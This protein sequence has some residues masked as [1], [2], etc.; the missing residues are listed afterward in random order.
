MRQGTKGPDSGLENGLAGLKMCRGLRRLA[1]NLIGAVACAAALLASPVAWAQD[2]LKIAA[3]VNDDVITQLDVYM[4]LRLAMLSAHL[5]DTPDTRQRLLPQVMRTLIDDHLKLQEAKS[6]GVTVG[7]GDVNNRIDNLA[8]RNGLSRADFESM[9]AS[10]GV[11]VTALADQMRADVSWNRLVQRK[12]R[13]TIRITDE[14][15]NEAEARDKA[16]LG[17]L[18]YHLSQIFLAV[19]APKDL[20]AVQQS[21]QRLLEQLQTGADF[22]S[23]ASQFSQDTSAALGG[24]IG[25]VR[26]DEV[27]PAIARELAQAGQGDAAKGKLLGPIQA[28]GG[29]VVDRIEDV[30]QVNLS[31]V[32]PGS[33]HMVQLIWP[34]P[35]NAADK[36]IEAAQQQADSLAG[37]PNTCQDFQRLA[38]SGATFRDFGR[39]A[40]DD[41]PP[42]IRQIATNQAIGTPTKGIRGDGGIAV[43]VVCDR[44]DSSGQISRVAIAD[45]LAQDRLETLARGYLSDL[46]RAA[47]IDIRL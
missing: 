21:A 4:R 38:P 45:R 25:W 19:D 10:N 17:K 15:I 2:E 46:R 20:P 34:L 9:L 23:L 5:Q 36:E 42:E 12:L 11:L 28:T 8:K 3:V 47:Y 39:I 29:I 6:E 1:L 37:T 14:E 13:P 24:D 35:P 32:A 26:A 16:A 44:G 22:A 30:R 18:E 31:S 43:F 40:L 27:D 7:D 33:V 41:M